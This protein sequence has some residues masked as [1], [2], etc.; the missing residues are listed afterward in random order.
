MNS[1]SGKS[2]Q[3]KVSNLRWLK[4]VSIL[5]RDAWKLS[6]DDSYGNDDDNATKQGYYWLKKVTDARAARAA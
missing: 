5:E 1:K 3:Y 2:S 6:K 4:P